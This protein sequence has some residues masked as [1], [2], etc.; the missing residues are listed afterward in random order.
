MNSVLGKHLYYQTTT[1]ALTLLLIRFRLAMNLFY[2]P[3]KCWVFL[4]HSAFQGAGIATLHQQVQRPFFEITMV[5]FFFILCWA[6]Q[7]MYLKHLGIVMTCRFRLS[8]Y[9]VWWSWYS[10]FVV[11]DVTGSWATLWVQGQK[12]MC[13]INVPSQVAIL[14][15]LSLEYWGVLISHMGLLILWI[16]ILHF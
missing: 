8:I 13:N 16:T 7:K 9:S 11:T 3:A 14:I 6:S 10:T 12:V 5:F 2:S 4:L 1:P 15:T